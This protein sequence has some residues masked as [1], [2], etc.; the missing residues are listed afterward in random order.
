MK[1]DL[2]TYMLYGG[3]PEIYRLDLIDKKEKLTSIAYQYASKDVFVYE[4]LKKL[5][6][7]LD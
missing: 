2:S 3:Y 5:L 1:S 6:L 7:F 4:G